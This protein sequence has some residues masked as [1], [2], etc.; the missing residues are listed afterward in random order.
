MHT[1]SALYGGRT[2]PYWGECP[3]QRRDWDASQ[4]QLSRV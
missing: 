1:V 3:G 4:G 2:G